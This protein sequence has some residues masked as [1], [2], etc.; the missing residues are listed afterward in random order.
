M[1]HVL[2]EV[3]Q[4]SKTFLEINKFKNCR[5]DPE[6]VNTFAKQEMASQKIKKK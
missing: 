6:N 2:L 5:N 3:L 1:S 4:K